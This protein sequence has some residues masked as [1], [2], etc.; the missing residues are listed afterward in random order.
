MTPSNLYVSHK[1]LQSREGNT[2]GDP[3]AMAMYGLAILH[4]IQK[5]SDD[6]LIQKWYADD[7]NA[8]GSV[9]ALKF[10]SKLKLHGP[11]FGYNVIKYH[12]ITKAEFVND[13]KNVVKGE[14]S[15]IIDGSRVLE[16]YRKRGILQT[17]HRRSKAKLSTYIAKISQ[18]RENCTSKC[19]QML[20]ELCAA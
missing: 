7:G 2:Q 17:I 19:V 5:V 14:E 15:D 16:S 1:V 8:A 10:L 20:D 6:N 9:K 12:L 13:A 3:L 4:L 11:S 18:T